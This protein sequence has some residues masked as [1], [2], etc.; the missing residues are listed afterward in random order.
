MPPLIYL[1]R[2]AETVFNK[3]ARMQ[4]SLAHTPLTRA[5]IAQAEAMGEA[6]A[7]HLGPLAASI[8]LWASPTGRTLQTAAIVAEHLGRPFFDVR[9]EPRL[10]EID[11]GDWTGRDYADILAEAGPFVCPDRRIFTQRPPGGEWY[12][13]IAA[14]VCDW[15]ETLDPAR[16]VLVISHGVT[17]RI[18]RGQL[19]GGTPF[20]PGCVPIAEEAPQG[21]VFRIEGGREQPVHVGSGSSG[22]HRAG[23]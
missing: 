3:A 18:L 7:A 17:A 21:T 1:A 23:F 6:L 8:D 22:A 12:P 15:L 14:R 13:D 2:H 10:V 5:G 20:E 4:G 16:P 19:V 11:V 9:Q